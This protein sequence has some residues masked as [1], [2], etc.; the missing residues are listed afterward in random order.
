MFGIAADFLKCS[1]FKKVNPFPYF[2]KPIGGA[3][4]LHGLF[5]LFLLF[6]LVGSTLSVLEAHAGISLFETVLF[7]G[8]KVGLILLL[9]VVA[10]EQL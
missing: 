1:T 5:S 7:L 2:T 3:L 6:S 9:R 8:L 4:S 10:S